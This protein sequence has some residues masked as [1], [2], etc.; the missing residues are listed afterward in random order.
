MAEN[1]HAHAIVVPFPVQGH[2][3]PSLNLA[4]KL[5]SQGFTITFVTTHF[6]HQQ[7]SQAHKNSTNTNHDMFFQA[8]NSGLDIRH[9]TVTDSFPL[10]FDRAGNQEQFWE[11]ML[12]VFPAHVDELVDQ[13]MKCSKPRP[14][15]LILDTFYN[16]GSQIANKFNLV[17]ISFW[18]QSALSFTLFYHWELFKK[19]GHFAS[20]DN[21]TDVIDY[22][23]GVQ[24]IKPADLI[25]YLQ[26]SD[27]TTVAHRTCFTAFED[28]RKADF[29]LANTIQEFETDTI[30]SI[31]FRQPF[32]YP[33]GPVFSTKSEQQASSALWSESDCEQWLST[34]PKGSVLYASF[35]SYARVTRHDIAEIAYGLMKSEVNFIW[36]IRDDIVGAHE[37]DFLPPEF[38]NGIKLKDQGLLVSWCSQTEVLSNAAIGGFLTHCGWN[39]ILESVWCEVPLLCFPIMTDQ[40]SNRKLVVDDWRIGVN[41][42]GAEEE[43]SREEVS[44]KVRNLISGEL[45]NELRV[46]IQKYKK[47]M[48]NGIMEGGSSHSNWNKFI[49]DIQI[50]KK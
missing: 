27:T 36:V 28:V 38:I 19:N 23:P 15:C 17:H 47:L 12:H 22:I 48:E 34:K 29:I 3:K 30:S 25:S 1:T 18:T 39:S 35:G 21:R 2:I 4:L 32:F 6:T 14:T 45:G 20:Q 16:W 13:L 24:E 41:L 44:M 9:V 26:M 10:G 11:G 49:H 33:I 46:Q 8:R 7:I 31:R 50:F 40:P 5:A 37:T 42:S 43:V